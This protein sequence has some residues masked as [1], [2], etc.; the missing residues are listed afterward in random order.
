MSL[1]NPMTRLP[2][3]RPVPIFRGLN[4]SALFQ[5]ARKS[6]EVSH[7]KGTVL[8]REGDPGDSL[9][10]IVEGVVDVVKE[11]HVIAQLSAGDYFGELSLIDGEP[12]S[13]TV[14]AVENVT[15][16]TLSSAEFDSL[17]GDPYFCRGILRSL[18]ERF[19]E[20]LN[21]QG[22]NEI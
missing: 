21:L 17:L 6:V 14:V 3:L 12:R 1:P 19:R 8:V 2:S 5:V 4:K 15:L 18:S 10:I 9:C 7:P 22:A 20:M 11:D 13:A 16:L